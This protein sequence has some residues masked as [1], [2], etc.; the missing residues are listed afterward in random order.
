[1]HVPGQYDQQIEDLLA[2]YNRQRE[3]AA[4]IRR[5]INATTAT[6]T[7]PRQ[8]VK[9]TVGAQGEVTAIEFPTGAY[10]RMPPKELA[11]VLLATI[12]QARSEVLQSTASILADE[13]PAGWDVLG[14]LQGKADPATV[15][16]EEPVMPQNAHDAI[17][18]GFRGNSHG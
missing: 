18:R 11:D 1:V 12:E 6:V 4:G 15:L 13:L 17:D 10:R 5:R 8:A 7:G 14:L 3:S 2:Q 9:V 16:P